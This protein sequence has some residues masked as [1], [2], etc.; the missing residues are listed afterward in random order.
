M[1][2]LINTLLPK[3][4]EQGFIITLL[5]IT[6]VVFYKKDELRRKLDLSER[7]ALQLKVD[8][9]EK[10]ITLYLKEDKAELIKLTTTVS[11]TLEKSNTLGERALNIIKE[12]SQAARCLSDG[13]KALQ[14][15]HLWENLN[16]KS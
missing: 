16:L 9:L 6:V 2:E 13:I 4:A 15:S 1:N 3:L 8:E 10:T 11:I 7:A 14:D 5:V 12:N